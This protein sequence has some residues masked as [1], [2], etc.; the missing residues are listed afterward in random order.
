[1]NCY[2]FVPEK[3]KGF[4][5]YFLTML[6][7]VFHA[8]GYSVLPIHTIFINGLNL[9]QTVLHFGGLAIPGIALCA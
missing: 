5:H 7:V 6:N 2:L 8:I 9:S 3:K 4:A 1:M